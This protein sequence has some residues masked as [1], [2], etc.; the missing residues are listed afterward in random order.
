MP[1]RYIPAIVVFLSATLLSLLLTGVFESLDDEAT[2]WLTRARGEQRA[3]TSIAILYFDNDDIAALG[4]WPLKRSL[5]ALLI[6]V[7]DRVGASAIGIDIFFGEEHREFPEYD[8]L[9]AATAARSGKVVFSSYFRQLQPDTPSRPSDVLP[10]HFFLKSS[11]QSLSGRQLQAPIAGLVQAAAGIGHTNLVPGST[12]E[13]PATIQLDGQSLLAFPLEVLRVSKKMNRESVFLESNRMV[14]AHPETPLSIPFRTQTNVRLN[15]PGSI[16]SFLHLRAVEVLR[17][18]EVHSLGGQS[19]NDLGMFRNKIVL[20]GVIAEGRSSFVESPFGSNFPA[21]ALHATAIDNAL[22]GRFILGV[23]WLLGT[24]IMVAFVFI[25][26]GAVIRLGDLF[27]FLAAFGLL[28]LHGSGSVLLFFSSAIALPLAQPVVTTLVAVLTLILVE[29]RLVRKRLHRAEAERLRVESDLRESE[30]KLQMLQREL[31]EDRG[32]KE[33]DDVNILEEI[34]RYKKEIRELSQRAEDLVVAA[35]K[36]PQENGMKEFHGIV[37]EAAGK[38]EEAI[39]LIK[40]I[41]PTDSSV[42]ILGESGTGKELIAKAIHNLSPRN[43]K[44]FVAINCAAIQESLLE[45][46]LFG[47]MKGSFTGAVSDKQGLLETAEGGTV[48]L[49]EIAETSDAFQVKLLR[50]L[51]EREIQRVGGTEVRKVDVRVLAATN[52]DIKRFLEERRFRED[53]YFRINVFVVHL[54][55]LRERKNDVPILIQHFLRRESE[56]LSVSATVRDIL[57]QYSWPGNV[58]ELQSAVR[59]GAILA[60]AEGRT[61]IR[62]KDLPPEIL[63]ASKASVDLEEQIIE[64]LRA[65]KFSRNSISETAE[66]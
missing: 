5:Y 32:Q 66:E 26:L 54:L 4:G 20:V 2:Q 41:A 19:P 63:D 11:A 34:R 47:H 42:L 49:D 51:Q 61:L 1:S 64:S 31:M 44:P 7:L 9:L 13:L 10:D 8:R 56:N 25:A 3:D 53:L 16:N 57:L 28:L 18:Y 43:K 60:R 65:K 23:S 52:K 30:L 12:L 50:V 33:R 15:V 22:N 14:F 6:D 27:G 35:V 48:F 29:H 59:R 38:M 62:S 39:E 37:Y 24:L 40:K 17:A 45:S 55:P 36:S 21:I 46:E 58:R